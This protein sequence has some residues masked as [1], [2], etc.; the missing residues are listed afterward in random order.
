MKFDFN[1]DHPIIIENALQK[2]WSERQRGIL[3]T[4]DDNG[5]PGYTAFGDLD[6]LQ[7]VGMLEIIKKLLI[8]NYD[9]GENE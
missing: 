9:V 1:E 4:I 6:Q 8:A 2:R 5:D 3:I 7:V